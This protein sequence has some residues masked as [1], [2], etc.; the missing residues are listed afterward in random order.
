MEAASRDCEAWF[1]EALKDKW[2]MGN[3]ISG[4]LTSRVWPDIPWIFIY[5]ATI[6][7]LWKGRNRWVF[8]KV[9]VSNQTFLM[10][11]KRAALEMHHAFSSTKDYDKQTHRKWAPPSPGWIKLNTDASIKGDF[12]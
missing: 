3:I 11:T 1:F 12:N 8:D 4:K 5:L 2:F 10:I 7:H 6:W 9:A